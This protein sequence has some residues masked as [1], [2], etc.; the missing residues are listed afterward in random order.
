M[1]IKCLITH[2][3]YKKKAPFKTVVLDECEVEKPKD[4]FA[5]YY[6]MN[7]AVNDKGFTLLSWRL[8]KNENFVKP[9]ENIND[10]YA[11]I[12]VE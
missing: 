12:I 6:N 1:K 10:Y 3:S 2:Y 9:L 4:H 11:E 8:V 7:N 5:F